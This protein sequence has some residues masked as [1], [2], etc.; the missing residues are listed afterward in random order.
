MKK[1]TFLLLLTFAFI[2]GKAQLQN[3]KWRGTITLD[4]EIDVVF[5]YKNDTLDVVSL[6]D[7]SSLESM[8][9]TSTDSV[10]NL[11]KINGQSNCDNSNM[12]KYK[13]SIKDDVLYLELLS[14]ICD[15]RSSVLSN[16]KWTKTK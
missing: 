14:D 16:S 10:L 3:T 8:T 13:F 4:T 2:N 1:V 15:D 11:K 7:G 5:N 12:G 9:Y 6:A